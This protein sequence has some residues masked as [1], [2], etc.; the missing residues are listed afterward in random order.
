M[1]NDTDD[2]PR[3]T[4]TA[5]VRLAVD[6]QG[7]GPSAGTISVY[8]RDGI[9]NPVKDTTGRHL[10]RPSNAR[11]ALQVYK[12]RRARHGKTGRPTR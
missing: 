3:L 12:A 2:V 10:F 9:L 6:E 7:C 11:I 1:T 4:I 5:L 8:V